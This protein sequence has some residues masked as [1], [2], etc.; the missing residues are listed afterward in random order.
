MVARFAE[1]VDAAV[2]QLRGTPESVLTEPR[3]VGRGKLPA[4]VIGLLLHAGDHTY[5]HVGQAI[6]TARMLSD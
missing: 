3:A 1:A 2:A 5:R 6:T 4:T